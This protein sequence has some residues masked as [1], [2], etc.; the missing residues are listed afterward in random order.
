MGRPFYMELQAIKGT[1]EAAQA[2]DEKDLYQFLTGDM[3]TPLLVIGSGGSYAVATGFVLCYQYMGGSAKAVTPYGLLDE[4]FSICS[5]K[6]LIVTAGGNNH[7]TVGAYEYV[8]LYEPKGIYVVCMSEKSKISRLICKNEDAGLTCFSV[9]NGK[10]GF[11]AVNS[12]VAMFTIMKKILMSGELQNFNESSNL[13]RKSKEVHMEQIQTLLVLYGGWG[14]PAAVDLESKCSEAGLYNVQC[15]DYRNFAHGRHNWIDKQQNHT[16]IVALSTKQ[17]ESIKKRTLRLLPD[18]VPVIELLS[19]KDSIDAAL[20]LI[21][22]VFYLVNWLGETR[23]IDPGRPQVPEYG[24]KLYSLQFNLATQ[25]TF[26]KM[27]KRNP[28]EQHL[29]RKLGS[30]YFEK[31]WHEYYEKK[32]VAFLDHVQNI[33]YKGL[34]LDYDGT[35][36]DSYGHISENTK[37]IL[38]HM[39]EYGCVIGVATGRGDSLIEQLKGIIDEKYHEKIWIG[40]YNGAVIGNIKDITEKIDQYH[41]VDKLEHFYK[42]LQGQSVFEGKIR[43]KPCQISIMEPAVMRREQLYELCL[44]LKAEAGIKDIKI[45]K[46]EHSIDVVA[47]AVDKME[48]VNELKKQ[49]GGDFLCIGDEGRIGSNDYEML[50]YNVG[51]STRESN[52]MGKSGWN[53]APIGVQGRKATE[54]YLQC[55]HVE[56]GYFTVEFE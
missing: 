9:P 15:A 5:S 19:E 23:G 24:G 38:N 55:L 41:P 48:L 3:E 49:Y 46:S 1:Y 25:D 39:L 56:A 37:D 40:S 13:Q 32:Y 52:C 2:I 50:A 16:M 34:I 6:I 54:Y 20:D 7:D 26:L 21:I 36:R 30:L 14:T 45:I 29:Y 42:I 31:D 17:E 51:L 53:L 44:E 47:C 35:I 8:R 22:Q 28:K 43:K 27:M 10:D 4:K 18:Q 11:L 33:Q 12:T